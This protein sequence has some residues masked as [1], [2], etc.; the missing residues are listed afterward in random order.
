MKTKTL[1]IFSLSLILQLVTSAFS[2]VQV[3]GYTL[4]KIEE[5]SVYV[6]KN[7]FT[8][9]S[10]RTQEALDLLK[11]KLQEVDRM[12]MSARS[13][14]KLRSVTFFVDWKRRDNSAAEYHPSKE[15]LILNG[16]KPEKAKSIN[17]T[18][19]NNFIDWTASNQPFMVLHE[20]THAYHDQVLGY[21][22]ADVQ[23]AFDNAI[24]LKKY[25]SVPYF[26]G[27]STFNQKAYA[28]NNSQEYFA[29]LTEAY[30]GKNDYYPFNKSELAKHDP[31]G[32]E[33]LQ[34]V[35]QND[36]SNS[37]NGFFSL[38]KINTTD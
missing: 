34:K 29:E 14:N 18:N 31:K 28:T 32:Y 11:I 10:K 38:T 24:K 36:G 27:R 2:M 3:D 4:K 12:N 25:E 17:I 37:N 20:L 1:Y 8:Q 6:E 13:K 15:W 33:M 23:G 22:N 30:F 16:W 26:N 35:W 7:A 9:S 5:R 21:D 19:I